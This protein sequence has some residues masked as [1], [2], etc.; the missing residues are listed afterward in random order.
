M[1]EVLSVSVD[2]SL[3]KQIE[4]VARNNNVPRSTVVKEALN[5]Y[6]TY[7]SFRNL[8]SK[9]IP[10]GERAGYFTDE[11]IFKDVS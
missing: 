1:R 8:R 4:K 3:K 6:L 7:K 5:R 10:Y 9:L 2:P 11:D